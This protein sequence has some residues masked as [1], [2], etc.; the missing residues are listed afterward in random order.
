MRSASSTGLRA[1]RRRRGRAPV[2]RRRPAPAQGCAAPAGDAA[3][4]GQPLEAGSR[5][6]R[7]ARCTAAAP[8][9]CSASATAAP[10]GSSSAR[11]PAR[12]RTG[13]ASRSSA[14]P[15]QLLNSMLRAI[16]LAARD[17]SSSPTC[18]SA[19]RRATAIRSRR[20]SRCC[21][22][23][24]Q[25]QIALVQ[26]RLML[27]V[28][29]IAAQNLLATDTPIGK[30]RGQRAPLRRRA[31]A[32]GRH[33]SSGLPAAL[34]GREAQGLGRPEFARRA[35]RGPGGR[36]L[37]WPGCAGDRMAELPRDIWCAT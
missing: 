24:L 27:A 6:A 13:R 14:A 33:L 16:G 31:D 37:M 11:R 8:R 29:R 2:A 7:A 12:R 10:T 22:P 36:R 30:L 25:R 21:L 1:A 23:Y 3:R 28:G 35:A 4:A 18:S 20:R 32:A 17:R 34:A 26:P 5:P 19:G 15:A 9:R